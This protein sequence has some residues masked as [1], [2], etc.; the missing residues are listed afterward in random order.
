MTL[1][2]YEY[3]GPAAVASV[4]GIT[5][6][7]AAKK[8]TPYKSRHCVHIDDIAAAVESTATY[9]RRRNRPTVAQWLRAHPTGSYVIRA[10]KHGMHIVDG[11]VVED[12]GYR[13]MRGRVTH[14]IELD[15]G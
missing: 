13:P 7:Q 10:A 11:E 5:R 9:V 12:N 2:F 3:C 8:L 14:V 1:S 6:K 4:L 15:A